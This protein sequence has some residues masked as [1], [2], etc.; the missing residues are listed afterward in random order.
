M[1]QMTSTTSRAGLDQ[2]AGQQAALAERVPAVQVA[3]RVGLG[4]EVERVAG[5]ARDDQAEGPVVV[6]VE[7]VVGDGL[8]DRLACRR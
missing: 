4:V 1:G 3:G 7:V 5:P 8:V 6:L 2:P